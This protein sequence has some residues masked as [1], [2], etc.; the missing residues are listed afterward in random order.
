[1]ARK[2]CKVIQDLLVRK[3]RLALPQLCQVLKV[4][5]AQLVLKGPQGLK[6]FPD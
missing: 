4:H 3:A 5:Q 6:E 2:V 1:L